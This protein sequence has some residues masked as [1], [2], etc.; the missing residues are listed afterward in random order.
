MS[1]EWQK[2]PKNHQLFAEM[3]QNEWQKNTHKLPISC[4]K[5]G[6]W[7]AKITQRSPKIENKFQKMA[8]HYS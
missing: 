7:V 8:N 1:N 5:S 3:W 2:A 4:K 6:K